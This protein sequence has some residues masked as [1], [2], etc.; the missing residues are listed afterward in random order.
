M[1]WIFLVEDD[2]VIV[3]NFIF[4]FNLEGFIVIYVF[5]RSEVFVEIVKNKFD[6]VFIDIFLFDGNGFMICIEIKEK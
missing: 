1:K 3:K 5:I 2:K 4:L 6:L